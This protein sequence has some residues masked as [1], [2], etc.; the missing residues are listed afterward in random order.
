[1]NTNGNFFVEVPGLDC[2]C[3][4]EIGLPLGKMILRISGDIWFMSVK[5][6]I[7]PFLER[8]RRSPSQL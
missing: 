3:Y 2:T 8:S 1:M 4:V 5:T 6:I 7:A